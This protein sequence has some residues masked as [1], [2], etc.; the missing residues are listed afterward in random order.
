MTDDEL[1]AAVGTEVMGW[2]KS[3]HDL[4]AQLD[5]GCRRCPSLTFRSATFMSSRWSPATDIADAFEVVERMRDT[6]NLDISID[7]AFNTDW[8]VD[9]TNEPTSRALAVYASA[10]APTLPRAICEAALQAVRS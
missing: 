3:S 1:N 6:H 9:F 5:A 2:T 4:A 8:R 7:R 10:R